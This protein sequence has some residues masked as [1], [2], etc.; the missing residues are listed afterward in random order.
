MVFEQ[1]HVLRV[2]EELIH[3]GEEAL[4]VRGVAVVLDGLSISI[5]D[6]GDLGFFGGVGVVGHVVAQWIAYSRGARKA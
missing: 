4:G 6:A 1:R 2:G 3:R 5:C